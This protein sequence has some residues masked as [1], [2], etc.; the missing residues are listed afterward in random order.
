MSELGEITQFKHSD[1]LQNA[2]FYSIL[3]PALQLLP[4]L[5]LFTLSP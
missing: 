1:D 4:K 2:A 5:L 3:I